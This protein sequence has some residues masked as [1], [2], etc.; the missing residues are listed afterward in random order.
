MLQN[1]FSSK[2]LAECIQKHCVKFIAIVALPC[3]ILASGIATFG[4]ST[5]TIFGPHT[6]VRNDGKPQEQVAT[7][8]LPPA[9]VG[10]YTL[11]IENGSAAETNRV[12]S[13]SVVLN[14]VQVF[15][16]SDFN[17]NVAMVQREVRLLPSNTLNVV[18]KSSPGAYITVTL[19]GILEITPEPLPE[20]V[21]GPLI[22]SLPPTAAMVGKPIQYQVIASSANSA[23]LLFSLS[24]A[25]TGMTIDA[26][27]GLVKWTPAANQVGDQS[28]T[29]VAQDSV[30][31][32][33]QSFTLSVFVGRPVVSQLVSAAAGGV[34]TVNDPTSTVNGLSISI[35]AGALVSDTTI[36]I[37]ELVSPPTFGGVPR[38]LLKGVSV[39]PDGTQL[40]IPATITMPYILS[41]FGTNAGIPL[42]NFLGVYFL[43]T[44]TGDPQLLSNFSVDRANHVLTGTVAHFS[45]FIGTN[46]TELCPPPI[47]GLV[48]CPSSWPDTPFLAIPAA[49]VH[50]FKGGRDTWGQLPSLLAQQG[51]HAYRFDYDS[52]HTPFEE[53]ARSFSDA[54]LAIEA[55]ENT[56]VVNVVAH[57][58][59][60]ILVRTYLQGAASFAPYGRD[61]NRVM[62]IGTPHQG[63]GGNFSLWTASACAEFAGL[64]GG[65]PTCFETG[66]AGTATLV[67]GE[68]DFL[69]KLNSKALPQ[70]P[71]SET[72]SPLT[73]QYDIITGQRF[74][75]FL[76]GLVKDD[77]L[78]TTDGNALCVPSP[79]VC[80]GVSYE[81]ET[82][83]GLEGFEGLA[84]L[85]HSG[86]LIPAVCDPLFNFPMVEISGSGHPLW[87]KVC[88]F[89]G[90]SPLLGHWTG[91]GMES[92]VGGNPTSDTTSA[93]ALIS[94]DPIT[95]A[96]TAT[97]ALTDTTGLR[98]L[99]TATLQMNSGN[100]TFMSSGSD[101]G[102]SIKNGTI[103]SD[104]T[105]MTFQGSGVVAASACSPP[106]SATGSLH[107]SSDGLTMAAIGT[108]TEC[109]QVT[110]WGGEID[111]SA[112]GRHLHGF[113]KSAGEAFTFTADKQ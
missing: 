7:F 79:V 39:E 34:V 99:G 54:L 40:T 111:F 37:S 48:D 51:V 68:G 101:G 29:I 4:Q 105:G 83:P 102:S 25:P 74:V 8:V 35:P 64:T 42:E 50:G 22:D 87:T 80:S 10:P 84:G 2:S 75:V 36:V 63:I 93:D 72:P 98:E 85:C 17:Q 62:T 104:L 18:L 14:G 53:S 60:G 12:S 6:F 19:T 46:S 100:F 20:G 86:A 26:T 76:N 45:V 11:T 52:V 70:L 96:I 33:S 61:V 47:D 108:D 15:G 109:L 106:E 113:A 65:L 95:K 9:V 28:V 89:L 78:I 67:P 97:V 91:T 3:L 16:P 56:S 1:Q 110:G 103:A 55:R 41:E 88:A 59:G 57:S 13:A 24:G 27:T 90:C 81:E 82:N 58:F 5:E 112:D 23:S 44:S 43:S 92:I 49:L 107:I 32:T 31:K 21:D 94:V 66:T 73:P 71:S 69:R 77:G 38:F 30:G